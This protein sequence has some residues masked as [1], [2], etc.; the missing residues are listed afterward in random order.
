MVQPATSANYDYSPGS[1]AQQSAWNI[2]VAQKFDGGSL[3]LPSIRS[4]NGD[5]GGNDG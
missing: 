2:E 4:K 5:A 3:A 1:Q